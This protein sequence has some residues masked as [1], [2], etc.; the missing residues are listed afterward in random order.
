[1][2]EQ[3]PGT[4]AG[5]PSVGLRTFIRRAE[6]AA[7]A[8]QERCDFCAEVVPASH[9]HLLEVM[10]REVSCVCVPCSI[11][12]D[13]DAASMG[14]YRLIPDRRLRLPETSVSDEDWAALE[15]P[16][17][18][19]FFTRSTP[20]GRVLAAYPSPAGAVESEVPIGGWP[21]TVPA[22]SVIATLKPDVEAVLVDRTR[23]RRRQWLVPID[24]CFR[25]VAVVRTTWKGLGGGTDAWREIGRFFDA[26]D[27]QARPLAGEAAEPPE[28]LQ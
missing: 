1:M 8:A 9:R 13:R 10:N 18:M 28:V 25:L 22:G 24:D 20:A 5:A 15:I 14:R 11:L 26:L 4:A 23:G 19:A 2:A 17:G 3:A 6:A 12:F 16:V 27:G 21:A 7:A